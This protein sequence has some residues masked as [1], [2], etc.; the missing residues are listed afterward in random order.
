M[1]GSC[2]PTEA[3]TREQLEAARQRDADVPCGSCR[4]CCTNDRVFLGPQDDPRAFRWHL[5]QGYPVLDRQPNGDCIYLTP[6]GCGIHGHAPQICR[7]M[8]CRVLVLLTPAEMQERRGRE[9]PQ[10]VHI[11]A[12]GRERLH[13]LPSPPQP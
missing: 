4:A 1:P 2:E 8:D 7:R 6:Q 3:W 12:A 13:T 9:N 11:Y 5:E 10:M